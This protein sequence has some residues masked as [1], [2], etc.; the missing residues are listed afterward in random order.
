MITMKSTEFL[1]AGLTDG[2]KHFSDDGTIISTIDSQ[3]RTLV[4][5]FSND[6]FDL[7]HGSN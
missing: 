2:Y 6:F 1:T 7:Y 5:T 4:K 3:G